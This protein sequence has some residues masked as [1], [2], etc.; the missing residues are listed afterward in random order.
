MTEGKDSETVKFTVEDNYV[1]IAYRKSVLRVCVTDFIKK[2]LIS[3]PLK[4]VKCLIGMIVSKYPSIK[5]EKEAI[6]LHWWIK[7]LPNPITAIIDVNDASWEVNHTIMTTEENLRWCL[8][9]IKVLELR[10]NDMCKKLDNQIT[11]CNYK[12]SRKRV[13][14]RHG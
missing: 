13:K 14:R 5:T 3:N 7:P 12:K 4:D 9:R 8:Q 1:Q 6:H 11:M 2:Y 10:G